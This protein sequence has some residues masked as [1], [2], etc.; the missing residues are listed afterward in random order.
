MSAPRRRAGVGRRS[1]AQA[2]RTTLGEEASWWCVCVSARISCTASPRRLGSR[3]SRPKST[4]WT[5]STRTRASWRRS[6]SSRGRPSGTSCRSSAHEVN[7]A[8]ARPRQPFFLRLSHKLEVRQLP[9][10]RRPGHGRKDVVPRP[11]L[12]QVRH[13]LPQPR[14]SVARAGARA[15]RT[16]TWPRSAARRADST[17]RIMDRAAG[18]LS[19]WTRGAWPRHPNG[20]VCSFRR[21]RWRCLCI[22][23]RRLS[24]WRA[25]SI[26][27]DSSS[28]S[29]PASSNQPCSSSS[30]RNVGSMLGNHRGRIGS[31]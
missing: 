31:R 23:A 16:D 8:P 24:A 26:S 28:S 2:S 17:G 22:P 9:P 19:G 30:Q 21:G 10:F 1:R 4:S 5:G 20:R 3:R 29:A 18:S 27:H 11:L 25:R 14:Y 15:L 13:A 7:S 6:F 12:R